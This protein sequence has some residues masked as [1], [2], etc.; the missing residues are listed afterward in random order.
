MGAHIPA[1]CL[2]GLLCA[3]Q[4]LLT[5]CD[6]PSGCR[7]GFSSNEYIFAT[8][9]K[10]LKKGRKLG[11][12]DFVEC[13]PRKHSRY[14]VGDP[15]FLLTM[16]GILKPKRHIRFHETEIPFSVTTWDAEGNKY[17]T[18][19]TI[20]RLE[21]SKE[22]SHR[23]GK[24]PLLTFSEKHTGLKRQKRD[25]V[26]PPIQMPENQ[27]GQFPKRLV[28]IKSNKDVKIFYSITGQGAD[29]PPEGVFIIEKETGWLQV[30]RPVDRE[31]YASYSLQ[32]HAVSV[33]G[34]PVEEPMDIKVIIIDQNDNK[35]QF[36][37]SIFRGFVR[38]GV[39]PG[40][41]V[42]N[43]TATD[44]DDPETV[45]AIIGY[46]I[47]EQIPADPSKEL[48]TV[49]KET[50][51]ISVLGT[52]LD[53][54]KVPEYTLIIQAADMEGTGLSTTATAI[55]QITDANDNA[56]VFDPIK[57]TA[58]VPENEVGFE[59]QRLS[60]T[61]NDEMKTPAWRAVYKIR[62]PE[63]SF[64]SIVTDPDTNDGILSTAKGLDYET[65]KQFVLQIT[66]ENEEPFTV[67]LPSSTATV[68][69]N[70]EDVNE[71]PFFVPA[72]NTVEVSEDLGPG[73][74][75][76]ALVA[77][78]PDKQQNQKLRY[79]IGNDPAKWITV[80]E[81]TG[82]VSNGNLDRESGFVKNNT[83]TIIMMV[84][85]DGIPF[86]T[87]TGTLVLQLLDVNDNG[88][89]PSPR[90]FTMCN[91]NPEPQELLISDADL[92]PNTYPYEVELTHGSDLIWVAEMKGRDSMTLNPKE[93]LKVGDYTVYVRLFDSQKR[94]QLTV[95]NV[96]ICSCEGNSVS[97][98][99]RLVSGV[100]LPMI[101]V[102]LGSIL[103][104][105]ILVL[106]LLLFLK[107][108]KPVKEPLLLPEDDTRDNIFYYGEEGGGEEDQD[109]D[110]SQ[111]HRGLDA[112]P[113]I[114]REDVVPMLM[115]A[116]QY[117]PRPSNPDEIGN[118]IE[119][120]L[121]AADN[122]PTAPPYDSLLV[123]DYEGSGSEAASLSSL[124]SSN[125]DMDQDYDALSEWGPRFRK[126]AD[127]Y[128]DC[129]HQRRLDPPKSQALCLLQAIL[130]TGVAEFNLNRPSRFNVPFECPAT[131]R[132]VPRQRR[133][134]QS[135][136]APDTV[137]ERS[138][139]T[140][141]HPI[142]HP[143]NP[144]G[145]NTR[146]DS[147][148]LLLCLLLQV[149]GGLAEWEICRFDFR[150][151]DYH[152]SVPRSLEPGTVIGQVAFNKC[153]DKSKMIFVSSDPDF[154]VTDDGSL[155]VRNPVNLHKPKALSIR[156]FEAGSFL[157]ETT[158][159]LKKQHHHKHAHHD[160]LPKLKRQKRVWVIPP[161]RIPEGERGPFPKRIIQVKS[162][163]AKE[164]EVFYSITG[165]GCDS[166]PVGTFIMER[167]TGWLNVTRPL[168]RENIAN[169]TIL[170]YA[171]SANGQPVE[172][173]IDIIIAVTDQNDNHPS[174]TQPIFEGA[175]AEGSKPG[176]PVMTVTATDKDDSVDANNGIVWYFITKQ[177]PN[178]PQSMF[179]IDS[180]TGLISVISS[181]LDREL[182]PQYTLTLN[183][184][185]QEGQGFVA[186]GTAV[187]TITD[188][189][190]NPP[191]F[192]P[193]TYTARVPENEVGFEV[194]TLT[195]TDADVPDTDC[196]RAKFE[197]I[198]G[199]DANSF[200]VTT[201]PD[202][203]A[204]ITTTK[205]LDFEMKKEYI[206]LVAATNPAK[207]TVPLVISTATVTVIVTDENEAPVFVPPEKKVSVPEDLP[208]GQ[209]VATYTAQDPDKAQ[210]Q[211]ITYYIGN[212]PAG[213]LSVNK[214]NG[215]ITGN[216]QLDRES[217]FVKNNTYT[218]IILAVDNATKPATGTGTLQITLQ[219]VND[220][221]P[222]LQYQDVVYCQ[223]SAEPLSITIIDRDETPFTD[224]FM[225][226]ISREA[227]ENW[228]VS[229]VNN[230]FMIKANREMEEETYTLQVTIADSQKLKNVTT[231]RIQV[232]ACAPESD[233]CIGVKALAGGLNIPLI[234]GI[235]AGILALL[236]LVLLLLLF[237]RRKKVVKEPLLPPEDDT[238]DNV[239]CYDEEGG[240]EEDQ[241]F[242]LGQL[243][244]GLDAR[245]E[246]I[247]NDVA[248]TLMPAPQY[249]PRPANPDEIGNFID[250]NLQA[251]DNDPTAPPYD[252]L[253]VFDYEGSGSEA[254]SLSSLNSSS[255][256]GDQDY[257]VLNDWGPRFTKLA[258]MYG[259]DED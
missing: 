161:V 149:I 233:S 26:V 113:D 210:P 220:N 63:A 86:A 236:I 23:K 203:M 193:V 60:V 200:C 178:L 217:M 244:R 102:I 164:M 219:D 99:D 224:P 185:D 166:P 146:L 6:N 241:D 256:G 125:S 228:T 92:P 29:M 18:S 184:I 93:E 179:T 154:E 4:I 59:V 187:I 223:K 111:L 10:V 82:I 194:V 110:L 47:L 114:M 170:V 40:T 46:S 20:Q 1:L 192:D 216:G 104:L 91:K 32:S 90:L 232:C 234:I 218:A 190:D 173:V 259:G 215:I 254:A 188:T 214:E 126:L 135:L 49:N 79:K 70:V 122:D 230:Q 7:P 27:R 140:P 206:L 83:Y 142:P 151:K 41:P 127:M 177:E 45:N 148:A 231:L 196:W 156:A 30:T 97:C 257:S 75:I 65:R 134:G 53:R 158:V 130:C 119:E 138:A 165:Q 168:D 251:A 19:V 38:E 55:I 221:G 147:R 13:T 128:G 129:P 95:V 87:G 44:A 150:D 80:S 171:I 226:E 153:D 120:N 191:I 133:A 199:N 167:T 240:G 35:P 227:R 204:L 84:I 145:R 57:Y 186:T 21:R 108:K 116:P 258:D 78:D 48:F 162:S 106:L 247:R 54:E 207:F 131:P 67:P 155:V 42:M 51:L 115:P 107:R 213:W 103:A 175:V 85:D 157:S 11:T 100:D 61:D 101:L 172:D 246:V 109:Y 237:V 195:V 77:Q 202:N 229:V 121:L 69:I 245:P 252:S 25:W 242:D 160:S 64:F 50:G 169:Y 238:R 16:D 239:Y 88:P 5:S 136:C 211:K 81:E 76:I 105:L 182:Y 181:G 205:G 132:E 94:A 73:Q 123:F 124:T 98:N 143:E 243:H 22:K 235:L 152:F 209:V 71:A 34:K 183:A 58:L 212:D 255:S 112:R 31:E 189:N 253:L 159:T 137:Q 163:F 118:F 96:T 198:K 39:Q 250:E 28:Q 201:T 12:V 14:D 176:T 3:L 249:R 43:V 72:V 197:I 144:M 8:D 117:R 17:S 62:G 66:V 141:G 74:K 52:G 89:V 225:A 222:F 24:Y 33:S 174:F 36:T 180:V 37:E 248:P 2:A 56:P 139:H 68:T 208:S 9:R 15:R